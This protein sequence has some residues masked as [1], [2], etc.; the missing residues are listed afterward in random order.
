M[1]N[2]LIVDDND[3]FRQSLHQVLARRFPSMGIDEVADG[4]AALHHMSSQRPD[5][6]FM[7]IRLPGMNGL[8]ITKLIKF[9]SIHTT[10][11]VLTSYDLPEYREAALRCGADHFI[12]KD[13]LNET[14]IAEIVDGIA[15]ESN[16]G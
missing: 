11:C 12:V 3:A 2:A 6:V 1:F 16:L 13:K 8:D 10:I 7:D 4:E 14:E 9:I 5:L 15:P